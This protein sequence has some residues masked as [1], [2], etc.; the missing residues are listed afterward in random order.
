M[1]I[2]VFA[3]RT[4]DSG[5]L[6]TPGIDELPKLVADPDVIVWVDIDTQGAETQRMLG[7][8]F[9]IH[10]LLIEDAFAD[11]PTPKI[12]QSDDYLYLIIHGLTD[13]DPSD[14]EVNTADL[15]IFLGK[16]WV[17]TYYRFPFS[18]LEETRR[19][20]TRDPKLL[21][22]GPAVIAHR[23]IDKTVDE[24]L[25]L[26]EKLDAEIDGI[27][28]AIVR[29]PDAALLERIFRMKHSLQRIRRVGLHQRLVL[30]RLARGEAPFI[31]EDIQPFFSDVFDHMV[32][33]TDLNDVYLDLTGSSMDAFLGIQSHR[34]NE[35]M[36]ILTVF[37]TLMLP[38]N[39]IAGVYGMNF[40]QMPGL[41]WRFGYET[42]LVTMVTIA[43]AMFFFFKRR[44][45]L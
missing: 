15:D 18:A 1:A 27:E 14:G 45:W 12:E 25:P 2:R 13:R 37:S 39:F 9:G 17:V 33:V 29:K 21:A 35:V 5:A 22:R 6:M 32:K 4:S 30:G 7:E 44:R 43:V 40:D 20:V 41:H 34:L 24:F 26:M 23:V 38:L 16:T 11:S 28:E 10:P 31:P 19:A 42:A 8:V 36:R 3:V